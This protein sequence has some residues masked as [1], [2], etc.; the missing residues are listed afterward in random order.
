MKN[1]I[2][3]ILMSLS[4]IGCSEKKALLTPAEMKEDIQFYFH[5]IRDIHPDPY[6]RYDS[7]TFVTLEA[8][9]IESCSQPMTARDFVI[10][11]NNTYSAGA[12]FCLAIK[13]SNAAI[14][15]GEE[16]G[17]DDYKAILILSS[18]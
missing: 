11:G 7:M 6:Q 18:Y 16:M 12:D 8:K 9:M 17:L 3:G 15:V 1:L 2:I 10:M 5:L 13:V 4:I 14:L